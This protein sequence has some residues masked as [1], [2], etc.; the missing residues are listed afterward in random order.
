[1]AD[2]LGVSEEDLQA[3]AKGVNA[4][5]AALQKLGFDQEAELGRGFDGLKLSGAPIGHA[6]AKAAFDG[7]CDRWEWGVR[8]LVSDANTIAQ[9]LGLSAGLYH[10]EDQYFMGKI[11]DIVVDGVGDPRTSDAAAATM[12]WRQI[13]SQGLDAYAPETAAQR[14]AALA[15]SKQNVASVWRD[16]LP[17]QM[18]TGHFQNPFDW[19][20]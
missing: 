3:A 18:V 19:G 2:S 13:G 9:D 17:D 8:S 15:A 20:R 14:A 16:S 10:D 6:D 1:M 7:F 11:K 4:V 12:G 5:I